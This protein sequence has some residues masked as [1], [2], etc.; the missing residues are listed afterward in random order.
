MRGKDILVTALAGLV[1]FGL[2]LAG[3][4]ERPAERPVSYQTAMNHR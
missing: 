3:V 2:G 4:A 1:L